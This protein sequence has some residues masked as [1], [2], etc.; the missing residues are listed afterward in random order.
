M[1][2]Q[3]HTSGSER[4]RY[5]RIAAGA[6]EVAQVVIGFAVEG[7]DP[8]DFVVESITTLINDA[9]AL[10]A[11]TP[12]SPR[13]RS[14]PLATNRGTTAFPQP[15]LS[16]TIRQI[17]T[18]DDQIAI[19]GGGLA[20]AISDAKQACK[21]LA[22]VGGRPNPSLLCAITA[23][24][25]RINARCHALGQLVDERNRAVSGLAGLP[26]ITRPIDDS[27][28]VVKATDDLRLL[29]PIDDSHL[30]VKATDDR[31]LAGPVDGAA[32]QAL[33]SSTSFVSPPLFQDIDDLIMASP[34]FEDVEGPIVASPRFQDIDDLISKADRLDNDNLRGGLGSI[35]GF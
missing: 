19:E 26:G 13:L 34:G 9:V 32:R 25:T 18:L 14:T 21:E 6:F 10:S 31:R 3:S 4:E 17:A 29:D 35:G 1:D 5:E 11:S 7:S 22:A 12:P 33:A 28:V 2:S 16:T 30:V 20:E 24:L 27:R 23:A 15:R 8:L